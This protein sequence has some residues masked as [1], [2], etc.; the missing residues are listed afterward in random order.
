MRTYFEPH[1]T[2]RAWGPNAWV[3]A[4][5]VSANS[6]S[7]P[8]NAGL[9][10]GTGVQILNNGVA[11]SGYV[12]SSSFASNVTTIVL[13]GAT[14]LTN[15]ANT[16]VRFG[17]AA[18]NPHL[19]K[20]FGIVDVQT[21]LV[22]RGAV[23]FTVGS[24][25]VVNGAW[26]F[27]TVPVF[28]GGAATVNGGELWMVTGSTTNLLGGNVVVDVHS[29]YIRF[30]ELGGTNRGARINLVAGLANA[31][32]DVWHTGNFDP[33]TKVNVAGDTMTGIL[34]HYA[35]TVS[36]QRVFQRYGWSNNI[37]RWA[38]AMESNAG[39]SLYSYDSA[40]ASPLLTLSIRSTSAGA[41]DV[42]AFRGN[43][44]W[45]AGNFDPDTKLTKAGDTASGQI[46]FTS[47]VTTTV[48]TATSG[49]GSIMLSTSGANVP[50]MSFHRSGTFACYLGLHTDNM[51]HVGGWSHGANSWKLWHAGAGALTTASAVTG[52]SL[53]ATG[54]GA[55]GTT[56][57]VGGATTM[58]GNL[59]V[60]GFMTTVQNLTV[61]G[62]TSATTGSF[63][64]NLN[65]G[66]LYSTGQIYGA[67]EVIA[68][69][70]VQ[71]VRWFHVGN[72]G[73][74][75]GQT[76]QGTYI[77]WNHNSGQGESGFFNN[78]GGGGGGFDFYYGT[79]G[80]YTRIARILG[81]GDFYSLSDAALK[82]DFVPIEPSRGVAFVRNVNSGFYTWIRDNRPDVGFL[83]N[84]VEEWTERLV[85]KDGFGVRSLAYQKITTYHHAALQYVLSET[86][87]LRVEVNQL[88]EQV[89][90]LGGA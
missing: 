84:D 17:G 86:E 12:A 89:K 4:T 8:G 59:T 31:S 11:R 32:A 38:W 25:S 3:R 44:V 83:A 73:G 9:E 34:N 21:S 48:A 49:L 2:D 43:T 58:A 50:M 35:G 67:A 78:R 64:G 87:Q 27:N 30:W 62:N 76:Q 65:V 37:Q 10:V 36:A 68:N 6:F 55:I 81:S 61:S 24:T 42:F 77:T 90:A 1:R 7:V 47:A 16:M 74:Y 63:S 82:K 66:T 40:G 54:A 28:A 79:G 46:A 15:S 23:E 22:A 69:T 19:A 39:M 80:S 13:E 51:L 14:N 72:S 75:G 88:K 26:Q 71:T 20:Q 41:G 60:N 29:D 70:F 45:H 33:A 56:L 85:N 53:T 18:G 5:Y 57:T 52:G